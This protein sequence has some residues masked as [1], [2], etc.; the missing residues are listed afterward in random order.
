MAENKEIGNYYLW[1]NCITLS[2]MLSIFTFQRVTMIF[3]VNVG[4]YG[5]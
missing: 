1:S 3:K 2:N 5:R 4:H